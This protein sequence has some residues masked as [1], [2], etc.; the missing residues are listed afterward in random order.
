[1][2]SD[3][4]FVRLLIKF[5]TFVASQFTDFF[6]RFV[7]TEKQN[8]Q[9]LPLFEMYGFRIKS[10]MAKPILADM[11]IYLFSQVADGKRAGRIAMVN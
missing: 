3:D 4:A 7:L 5:T 1:M 2:L 11:S 6:H 10:R 8:P 9:T